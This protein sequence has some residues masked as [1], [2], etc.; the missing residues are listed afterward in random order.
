M[1]APAN[2]KYTKTHEWVLVEGDVGTVGITDHAQQELGDVTYLELPDTGESVSAGEPFGVV[3]S[4]KAA[5]D[6]YAPLDGE[7]V[8]RNDGVIDAP[9]VVNSSPYEGAWLIKVRISD[10][11]QLDSLMDPA[12]YSTYAESA[13]H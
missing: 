10:P 2:L 4:V 8:E 6:I 12:E 7:V 13:S 9:E 3:E 1:S 5:T 11:A